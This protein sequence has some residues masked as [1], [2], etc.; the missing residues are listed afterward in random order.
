MD[1]IL[2]ENFSRVRLDYFND[3]KI[4]E[5]KIYFFCFQYRDIFYAEQLPLTFTHAVK[6][7]LKL[8]DNTPIYLYTKNYRR[9]PA[10]INELKKQTDELMRKNNN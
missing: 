6:H 9:P 4:R 1:K 8:T 2:K 3:E 7:K 5:I 10:E